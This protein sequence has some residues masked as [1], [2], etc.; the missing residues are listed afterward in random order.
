MRKR[1]L[2]CVKMTL[3]GDPT[4]LMMNLYVNPFFPSMEHIYLRQ[5]DIVEN[6][7]LHQSGCMVAL[8]NIDSKAKHLLGRSAVLI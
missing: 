6:P 2:G 4:T 7:G 8:C 1:R 3:K 5:Y